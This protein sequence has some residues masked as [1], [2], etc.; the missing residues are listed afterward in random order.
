MNYYEMITAR[1]AEVQMLEH[2]GG[3]EELYALDSAVRQMFKEPIMMWS[4]GLISCVELYH[5][6]SAALATE[7]K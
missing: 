7:V 1:K 6:L 5:M 2:L 4:E 3:D